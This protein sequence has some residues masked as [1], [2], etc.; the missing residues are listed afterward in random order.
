[1]DMKTVPYPPYSPDFAP[2]DFWLFHKLKEKLRGCL[3][4]TIQ[5]MIVAV[6]K[7]VEKLWKNATETYGMLQIAFRPSCIN[8]ASVFEWHKRFKEARETVKDVE[9]C[10]RSKEVKGYG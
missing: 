9:T 1:M 6:T 3:Y 5:E 7:V 8:Q 10:W 2:C 4:V